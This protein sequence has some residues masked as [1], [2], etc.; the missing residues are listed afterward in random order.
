VGD[1]LNPRRKVW[2]EGFHFREEEGVGHWD[3]DPRRVASLDEVAEELRV[4]WAEVG[5]ED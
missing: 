4:A 1:P 2:A 5:R 3:L